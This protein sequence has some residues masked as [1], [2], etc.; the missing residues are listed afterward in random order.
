VI[1]RP[2]PPETPAARPEARAARLAVLIA[3]PIA[4]AAGVTTFLLLGQAPAGPDTPA[5]TTGPRT[6]TVP[7]APVRVAAPPLDGLARAACRALISELPAAVRGLPRRA[8]TAGPEQNAAYGE[9]P[10]TLACGGPAPS[11]G[12]TDDV[13]VLS[14][15]CWH[16]T[17]GPAGSVWTTLDRAVPVRVTVPAAYDPPGQWVIAFSGPVA[18]TLAPSG[19]APSG[20]HSPS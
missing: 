19:T 20:C 4:L 2:D 15:V 11:Y 6:A 17:A 1:R 7:A 3:V 14:G 13:S 16:A 12:L 10:V 9:P 8:V 18:A 5:A